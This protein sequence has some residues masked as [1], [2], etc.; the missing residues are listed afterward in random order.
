MKNTKRSLLCLSVLSVLCLSGCNNKTA[1]DKG[2]KWTSEGE[3]EYNKLADVKRSQTYSVYV[4][5]LPTSLNSV[6]T[7]QKE[8]SEYITNIVEGLVQVN[9]YGRIVPD[10]AESWTVNSDSSE[11]VFKIRDGVKWVTNDGTPYKVHGKQAYVTASDFVTSLKENLNFSNGSDSSYLPSIFIQGAQ[12]YY[13]YTLLVYRKAIGQ[14]WLDKTAF[15]AAEPSDKNSAEHKAWTTCSEAVPSHSGFVGTSSPCISYGGEITEQIM[16]AQ[17]GVKVDELA[18]I[19]NFSRVGIAASDDGKTLTYKLNESMPYF[20]S[21][22]TYTPFLPVQTDFYYDVTAEEF[23]KSR[24]KVLSNG[25]FYIS[26]YEMGI[27][28]SLVL[29]KNPHYF[30]HENVTVGTV[31]CF[32]FPDNAGEDQARL[33]FESGAVDGFSVNA[34]DKEG[35][36]KYVTGKDGTGTRDNPADPNAFSLESVGDG[37]SFVFALNTHRQ[38]SGSAI[39]KTVFDKGVSWMNDSLQAKT[40]SGDSIQIQNT[41][42]ALQIK[43]V[44]NLILSSIDYPDINRRFADDDD[45]YGQNRYLINTFTPHDFINVSGTRTDGSSANVKSPDY[46]SYIEGA[47]IDKYLEGGRDKEE[48][49][50]KA[51]EVLGYSKIGGLGVSTKANAEQT[52]ADMAAYTAE[53]QKLY[54]QAAADIKSYNATAETKITLPIYIEYVGLAYNSI[55][56]DNDRAWVNQTNANMNGC[57][58]G[59][60]SVDVKSGSDEEISKGRPANPTTCSAVSGTDPTYGNN[61][62]VRLIKNTKTNVAT[63]EDYVSITQNMATTIFV[64]GWGPDYSDPLT[65]ANTVKKNGDLCDYFGICASDDPAVDAEVDTIIGEYTRLVEEAS[66]ITNQVERAE[67]FAKAEIELLFNTYIMRPWYMA[68]QG[69]SVSVTRTI[70]YR[71]TTVPFGTCQYRYKNIERISTPLSA[72]TKAA[73]KQEYD[74]LKIIDLKKGPFE[75]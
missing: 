42:R 60:G 69:I 64:T 11:Y 47:Y 41:N 62:L 28:Q 9:R 6:T 70:P 32:K 26:N 50:T 65:F 34:K 66:K 59:T 8:D 46:Q 52:D 63:R 15:E 14:K 16:A 29:T 58:V 4:S 22:L 37:S 73:L 68:G 17:L 31:K 2:V 67:A 21:A 54:E 1:W 36:E 71:T 7:M 53:Y 24:E 18:A 56:D 5:D 75:K 38:T 44:R 61:E 55:E 72:E 74:A 49:W 10:V 19:E 12:E 20:L 33:G 48:N 39:S 25:P 51:G 30:D 45:V 57:W 35:W 13:N 27:S 40:S 23:G 3:T 43:S